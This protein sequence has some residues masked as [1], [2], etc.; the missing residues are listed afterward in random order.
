[1]PRQL[2]S[3]ERYNFFGIAAVLKERE[4]KWISRADWFL[5]CIIFPA[6]SPTAS[7]SGKV[8]RT[9]HVNIVLYDTLSVCRV[10]NE[11]GCDIN[12]EASMTLMHLDE[13]RI[14]ESSSITTAITAAVISAWIS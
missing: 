1:M 6:I 13:R 10:S 12:G 3:E 4:F 5:F 7:Y 9:V 11:D 14:I 2:S 8:S